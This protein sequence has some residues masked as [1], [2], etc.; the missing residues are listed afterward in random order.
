MLDANLNRAREGLRV[1]EDTARFVW[2]DQS[3][4]KSLRQCR[5]ELDRA[6]RSAYPNLVG[7]RESAADMGRRMEEGTS[8]DWPGL[9]AANFRRVQEALRVLEEYGKVFSIG[10][11][12]RFK[13]VRFRIYSDEK[14]ALAHLEN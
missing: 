8:R 7:G 11:V 1:L 5:H 6:T 4:F 3:L 10:A 2:E 13:A 14:K 12:S 9:V